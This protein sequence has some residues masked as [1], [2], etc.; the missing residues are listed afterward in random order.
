MMVA[1]YFA[2]RPGDVPLTVDLDADEGRVVTIELGVETEG[3]RVVCDG[4]ERALE[5]L[6][7]KGITKCVSVSR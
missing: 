7:A 4:L 1:F 6:Q 3:Y 5:I 2:E